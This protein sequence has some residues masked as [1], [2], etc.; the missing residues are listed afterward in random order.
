MSAGWLAVVVIVLGACS[1]A[2]DG[3]PSDETQVDRKVT[4]CVKLQ[5][6]HGADQ[7]ADAF[8]SKTQIHKNFGE[9]QQLRVSARD[10]ALLK[11]DLSAIPPGATVTRATLQLFANETGDGTIR[12]HRVTAPW[13]ESSVTYA[14][15]DQSFTSETVAALRFDS[16][17]GSSHPTQ[18][19]VDVTALV[20][21]WVSGQRPNRGLLLE[22]GPDH[23]PR[24]D[25]DHDED[26]DPTLFASSEGPSGRRPAL[27]VCYAVFVDECADAPC[28]NGGTCTN[29]NSGYTCACAPGYQGATCDDVIDHCAANPCE[30]G[31]GCTNTA[32]G[33]ACAC[34]AGYAGANCETDIDDCAGNPCANGGVC[35]DGV[36]SYACACAPGYDG[37]NCEHLIDN[38]E[39]APCHNGGTCANHAGGFECTCAAGYGGATCDT[40]IDDCVGNAC[41]NGT[42]ID[43]IG[44]YTCAC[45]P[46]WGGAHCDVNLDSCAQ[47]P[48]QNGGTCTNG[49]GSYTC[50]CAA[51]YTGANCE[52]DVDDCAGAPCQNQGRCIDGVA[53]YTCDCDDGFEGAHCEIV[54]PP[55]V[56][57]RLSDGNCYAICQTAL[58][59]DGNGWSS[60]HG[61]GCIMPS[62][63]DATSSPFCDTVRPQT[64][65]EAPHAPTSESTTSVATIPRPPV[66]SVGPRASCPYDA[67]GLTAWDPA[68]SV[69]GG[70]VEIPANTRVLVRGNLDIAETVSL[71]RI[72]VPATSALVFADVP[73]TIHVTDLSVD[74]ELL[75]GSATCRLESA[76]NVVFDTDEDVSSAAVRSQIV[77]RMGLGLMVGPTGVLE[78]F[79]H[80]YQPTWT[81]LGAT[82]SPGATSVTLAETVD[83]RIGD[84]IVI[85]T[86]SRFDY[87]YMDEN[88]V[89]TITGI[90]GNVVTFA[91]PLG[92]QH[93]G[94]PEYQIEVGL[95]SRNVKFTTAER[96][97]AAAPTFG[98][99][100]MVHSKNARISGVEL[101]GLGQQNF[102]ARY[103]F[104][105][106]RV[107]D[108]NNASYFTD[109]S[110]WRSNYRCVV[111]HR[112][113]RA[114]VS[115]NVAFDNFGH[116]FYFEDGV[117]MNNEMSFNL[118]VRTKYLGAT[119][120][121]SAGQEGFTVTQASD[122]AQP[123]DRAAA[124]FY[125]TN[126][127]NRIIGNASSGGFA[128]FSLP[129]LPKAIGGG[130]PE[131]IFPIRYGVSH[132]DGNTAH[133]AGYFWSD[134]GACIYVGGTLTEGSD[135][136]LTYKSGRETAWDLLRHYETEVFN[137]T[138]TFLCES[139]IVHWGNK[140]RVVNFEA[141]D[142][143][144]MAKLFGS[145]SFESSL[146][147]G[148]TDNP[149]RPAVFLSQWSA[150]LSGPRQGLK[151]GFQF[152]DTGTQTILDNV[153]FRNYRHLVPNG[154]SSGKE[155]D[156]C[157]LMSMTHSDEFT[158][159]RMNSVAGIHYANTDDAMRL[160]ITDRGTLASRNFNVIDF[161]GS[162]SSSISTTMATPRLVASAYAPSWSFR[163]EC[164]ASAPWGAVVCPLDAPRGVAS[165]GISPNR[166]ARVT[167]YTLDNR[168]IGDNWYSTTSEF[169][170][171]QI[172]GPSG[173]GWH[174]AFANGV[175]GA[176]TIDV[177]QVPDDS[178]VLF[179]F[180]LPANSTCRVPGWPTAASLSAL[181]ASPQAS[182]VVA[183]N[184]CFLR[185]PPTNLGAF[186]ASGLFVPNMMWGGVPISVETTCAGCPAVST[187]PTLP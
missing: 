159:Q 6:G 104:H 174:H 105:F 18:K 121:V 134:G 24:C 65:Y 35:S 146:S 170:V 179:S 3:P 30:N 109:S 137:N 80:L 83:W 9:R 181:L 108:V 184:T 52:I 116:C 99:H 2:A 72:H 43:G 57:V 62:N 117:E 131:R 92:F 28:H 76:I 54:V 68:W 180:T 48:C 46:D 145:A 135:G 60:E 129:N 5:R 14:S 71:R 53:S 29:G 25:H 138:K 133:S 90:S 164:V 103:P 31:G 91:Q 113:D 66:V 39:S 112:T 187:V 185:I 27:E 158:P 162:L 78:V 36:A 26:N 153:V 88:E 79:G 73:A 95:L 19:S 96:V 149:E 140:A 97:L 44:D 17:H 123:A 16:R 186:A 177:W 144:M 141:W 114:I 127:N 165:I 163:P 118:A 7:V 124:G 156:Q 55:P 37:A 152:Y 102:L 115:R 70:D 81:R 183:Q 41:V 173:L 139:G 167:M 1:T 22:A 128:G 161:D 21:T 77:S 166:G 42:C 33:Y 12:V 136:K 125:I 34:P 69:S 94:G 61:H 100:L 122:L 49:F 160:C 8:I 155:F 154:G 142:N 106:H 175:P 40:N 132:F 82:A 157:A 20:G 75:L 51:G 11:F 67:P 98:G 110:V 126:G 93:Y 89:R 120:P 101:Y 150:F 130:S 176:F 32:D 172:A 4:T 85:A 151:R 86:G 38:C 148:A 13:Q 47:A 119:P 87:P 111:V 63:P 171:A 143:G 23:R 182:F 56:L 64:A 169:D 15:F 74:G 147:V 59:P 10:E 50:G 84:K 178:F 45:S 168:V 58:D 107:G